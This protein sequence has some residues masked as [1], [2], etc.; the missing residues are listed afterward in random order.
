MLFDHRQLLMLLISAQ[1]FR[2]LA[3]LEYSRFVSDCI[4]SGAGWIS[5]FEPA[6]SADAITSL[7]DHIREAAT[8]ENI[9]NLAALGCM[10][11]LARVLGHN[12]LEDPSM[13]WVRQVLDDTTLVG[14]IRRAD[15]LHAHAV[16]EIRN[17]CGENGILRVNALRNLVDLASDAEIDDVDVVLSAVLAQSSG[18]DT[19]TVQALS[20]ASQ[21]YTRRASNLPTGLVVGI[22]SI[23]GLGWLEGPIGKDL[24][25]NPA[26]TE[27]LDTKSVLAGLDALLE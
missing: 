3:D 23:L 27:L 22:D 26:D 17:R 16:R 7:C 24:I 14:D 13:P 2:H 5:E 4:E 19:A 10:V 1:Q 15:T 9:S 6:P 8:F 25:H 12:F 11:D 20:S 21:N 18:F